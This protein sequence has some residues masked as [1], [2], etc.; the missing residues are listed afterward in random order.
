[1]L[2]TLV[3]LLMFAVGL[4]MGF[5]MVSGLERAYAMLQWREVDALIVDCDLEVRNS[6]KG[7]N[8]YKVTGQY[9]YNVD[10]IQYNNDRIALTSGSDN[11]GPFQRNA[12][13]KLKSALDSKRP[14]KCYVN[15]DNPY[16]SILFREPRAQLL[17]FQIIFVLLFGGSGL[18]MFLNSLF[19]AAENSTGGS[20]SGSNVFGATANAA[21]IRMRGS[22][23][24]KIAFVTALYT[25][26][27]G[28]WVLTRSLQ[29]IGIRNIPLYLWSVALSGLLPL[30][31]AL[32]LFGRMR[33]YGVSYLELS[34]L[35]VVAGGTLTGNI[36]I[37]VASNMGESF[38]AELCC[39]HQ[40]ITR[41]GKNSRTTRIVLW[42]SEVAVDSVYSYGT[43]SI[44]PVRFEL[45]GHL[46]A[47]TAAGNCDGYYWQMKV[48]GKRRGI[49]YHAVFDVPVKSAQ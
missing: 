19:A 34:S 11:V 8:T 38:V 46:P 36:H 29:I 45:P 14:V 18:V 9:S 10:G 22:Y 20:F 48:K 49:D 4:G 33:K 7:G 2:K 15:P 28:V 5:F 31:V 1:M 12:Y 25:G 35:P 3:G 13:Y 30:A 43:D 6:S 42:K 16:D 24:Y 40:Y 32:Y 39:I 26:G 47:T 37:P 41:S 27:C 44:L 17:T 23:A 21:R